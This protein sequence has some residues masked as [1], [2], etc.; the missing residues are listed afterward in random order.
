MGYIYLFQ[1]FQ[2]TFWYFAKCVGIRWICDVVVF[3]CEVYQI[4]DELRRGDFFYSFL[5]NHPLL[6]LFLIT[7][8]LTFLPFLFSYIDLQLP[9]VSSKLP[10]KR[11]NGLWILRMSFTLTWV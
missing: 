8:L 9:Y 5:V 10:I 1:G 4:L 2:I 3:I 6:S 7:L 11:S